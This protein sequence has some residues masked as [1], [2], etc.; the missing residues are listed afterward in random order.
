MTTCVYVHRSGKAC[1]VK[2][3]LDG[4]TLCPSHRRCGQQRPC[5]VCEDWSV[6]KWEALNRRISETKK[7]SSRS[8]EGKLD[9]MVDGFGIIPGAC[10]EVANG[11]NPDACISVA[12]GISPG[13]TTIGTSELKLAQILSAQTN[14]QLTIVIP[15]P[16]GVESTRPTGPEPVLGGRGDPRSPGRE[17]GPGRREPHGILA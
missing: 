1:G 7:K 8:R 14:T 17:P 6:E 16:E 9:S 5:E 4:H 2:F 15:A 10:T 12:P 11:V 3:S 13:L